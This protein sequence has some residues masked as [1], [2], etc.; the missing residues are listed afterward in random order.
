[1]ERDPVESSAVAT[2]GYDYRT[3]TLQ[4]EF[5]SGRVY[6]YYHVPARVYRDFMES[7]SKG[8]FLNHHIVPDYECKR[9][10]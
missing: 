8:E 9:I 5:P 3:R 4:V 1:M 10:R 6:E 2:I 7:S